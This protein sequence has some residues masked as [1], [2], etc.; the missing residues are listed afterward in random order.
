[1][2]SVA[3]PSKTPLPVSTLSPTPTRANSRP[4]RAPLSSSRITGSSGERVRRT[5]RNQL[6]P[7]RVRL[8]WPTTVRSAYPS[9]PAAI[10][11]TI[12]AISGDSNGCGSTTL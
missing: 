6:R 11:S 10:N 7:P 3:M 8:A 5:N 4:T 2:H 1:M 12:T 9:R